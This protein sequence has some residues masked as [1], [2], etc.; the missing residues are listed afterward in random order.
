MSSVSRL[1]FFFLSSFFNKASI[2]V[3]SEI[4]HNLRLSFF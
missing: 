1:I 3:E 2:V 4:V